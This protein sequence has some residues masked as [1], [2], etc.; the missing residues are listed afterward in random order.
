MT[1]RSPGT[2]APLHRRTEKALERKAALVARYLEEGMTEE[3]AT[4]RAHAEMRD[5][6]K[7]D[8]RRG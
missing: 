5:N 6:G 4:E 7:G 1:V 2:N 8:W 3:E